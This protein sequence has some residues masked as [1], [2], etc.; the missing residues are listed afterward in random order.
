[1]S[2]LKTSNIQHPSA[3]SPSI[4]LDSDGGI[5][6]FFSAEPQ[7]GQV[8]AYNAT[9][10][11]WEA[12][13]MK[14]KEK[15]IA[16]FT[17]SGT[18]TVPA[19]VTYA[20]AHMLGGGGGMG[21]MASNAGDGAGSSVAFASGT[22]TS[23]GGHKGRVDAPST[24]TSDAFAGKANSGRG[25]FALAAD[26]TA[27]GGASASNAGDSTYIVAGAAVTPAASITVTVGAGGAAGTNGAAGG[28]GYVYIEYYEEV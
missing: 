17:G 4:E 14:M 12:K 8:L 15:R 18:W 11:K 1:M 6:F 22:V 19:G 21:V 10:G 23:N 28:S 20:I 24:L 25:A 9:D 13:D 5:N 26:I 16:R 27:D 7:D 3:S 2:T